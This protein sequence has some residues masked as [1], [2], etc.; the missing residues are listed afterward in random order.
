MKIYRAQTGPRLAN[1]SVL[2]LLGVAACSGEDGAVVSDSEWLGSVSTEGAVTTVVN[3][4]GQVWTA[5]S[6]IE[7]LSIGTIDG[8][9][10][11]VFADIRALALDAGQI[12]VL[13]RAAAVV[14][15][16]GRDGRHRFDVGGPGEGPGEFR[17]P[18]AI[19]LGDDGRL[20]VRD[21]AQQ[22]MNE[23][24]IDDG[25]LVRDW[26]VGGAGQAVWQRDGTVWVYTRV[27]ERTATGMVN[28]SMLHQSPAGSGDHVLLPAT[29]DPAFVSEDR[30]GLEIAVVQG[31]SRGMQGVHL[32]P[33]SPQRTWT[34]SVAGELVLGEGHEYAFWRR[35]LDGTEIQVRR[36][37]PPVALEDDEADW[38]RDRLIAFWR[39]VRQD[40]VWEAELPMVKRSYAR[41]TLDDLGRVWVL[42]ELAGERV[43]ECDSDP[44]D[45]NGYLNRPCWR[46]PFV[47]D[48]FGE[49]GRFLG[50]LDVPADW[51]TDTP[52]H[53]RGD[54]VLAVTEDVSGAIRLKLY[55]LVTG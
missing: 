16:Y 23:F 22:R 25:Q 19:G 26:R 38:Y 37:I 44:E 31:R 29:P 40:F 14:R 30:R 46:Q 27:E 4:S 24:S 42:R 17:A 1:W 55:R 15:V 5:P 53:V 36:D 49:D 47:Y 8:D 2:V 48:V 7:E 18:T 45:L 10:A 21:T 28:W 51:R 3:E 12:Y 41:V 9:D 35:S 32:I 6:L 39:E 54:V 34:F 50:A 20:F 13:D 52:I 43:E 11:Y 33:F